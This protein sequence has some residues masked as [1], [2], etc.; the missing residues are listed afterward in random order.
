VKYLTKFAHSVVY[1]FH[2]FHHC[3]SGAF[4]LSTHLFLLNCFVWIIYTVDIL[5]FKKKPLH[6]INWSL[7]HCQVYFENQTEDIWGPEFTFCCPSKSPRMWLKLLQK[8]LHT[9]VY[10]STIYNS[11]AM[12][13]AKITNYQRMDQENVVFIHNG[14]LFSH[15]E[16]WNFVICK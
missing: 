5:K 4:F 15:K 6:D 2:F 10:Y 3:R 8:H 7:F 12:E 13:A 1:D 14:I 16:E 11:Q 9:H